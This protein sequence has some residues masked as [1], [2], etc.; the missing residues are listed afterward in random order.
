[1]MKRPV[2]LDGTGTVDLIARMRHRRVF[3]TVRNA[4]ISQHVVDIGHEIVRIS[5]RGCRRCHTRDDPLLTA[6][7]TLVSRRG[8]CP[9]S[10]II[11]GQCTLALKAKLSR[12]HI[13]A[14]EGDLARNS[15]L[16]FQPLGDVGGQT[17]LQVSESAFSAGGR[18]T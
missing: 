15:N 9:G 4:R 18:G 7:P 16:R 8:R 2:G 12:H 17:R 11:S 5:H 10:A 1:M 14:L 13:C 3:I 6:C